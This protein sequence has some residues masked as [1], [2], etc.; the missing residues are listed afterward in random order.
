MDHLNFSGSTRCGG[1][2]SLLMGALKHL[3][4]LG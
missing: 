3:E 1:L 4:E 2:D